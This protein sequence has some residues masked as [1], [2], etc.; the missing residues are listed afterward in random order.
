MVALAAPDPGWEQKVEHRLSRRLAEHAEDL[1][2]GHEGAARGGS[3]TGV[4]SRG[5]LV[6]AWTEVFRRHC[7]RVLADFAGLLHEGGGIGA[8]AWLEQR[9]SAHIDGVV[10][11]TLQALAEHRTEGMSVTSSERK[12]FANLACGLK[13]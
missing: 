5:L 9:F 2:R 8:V 6:N 7:D 11:R 4:E 12:R 13:A 1:D 3:R 10:E